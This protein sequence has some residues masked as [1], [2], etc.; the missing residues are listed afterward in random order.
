[1]N[2]LGN[3]PM[4][5]LVERLLNE[6]RDARP[7]TID[8]Y[9]AVAK[10]F[11]EFSAKKAASLVTRQDIV[12]FKDALTRLPVNWSKRFPGMSPAEAIAENEKRKSPTLAPR[13]I[14]DSYLVYVNTFFKWALS[15]NIRTDNPAVGVTVMTPK[16]FNKKQSRDSF[17]VCHLQAIFDAPIFRGCLGPDRPYS[18][19]SF[20]I[21]DHR[22]WVPLVALYSGARLNELGQLEVRDV[23][24]IGGIPCFRIT[25]QSDLH[26]G[27]NI[28]ILKTK[29]SA[30]SVP[31][32]P[33]LKALGFLE[34]VAA[35]RAA[36]D[37]R[38]FPNWHKGKDGTYSSVFSKSF[39]GQF[40]PKVGIKTPKLVFH[41]FRHT[42]ID[43]MR[44]AGIEDGVQKAIVGHSDQSTT[45]IYG[46]GQPILRLAGA[47]DKI[48]YAGLT[49][50]NLLPTG[51]ESQFPKVAA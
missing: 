13:N 50:T 43:A 29:S 24:E 22:F 20:L 35:R 18:P 9:R 40:L 1:L 49:L 4:T 45:A 27:E 23:Q 25:S 26:S 2:P 38:V 47:I 10:L 46:A 17:A 41:S 51:V 7:K 48:C 33:M 28:K 15:N 31:L 21:R 19:G 5:V 36:G 12:D 16:G 32:H 11:D 14:K 39:N 37:F 30:R 8:K 6:K 34:Y 3:Q 42:F 44:E